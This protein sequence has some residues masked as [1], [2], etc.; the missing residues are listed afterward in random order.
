MTTTMG[1]PAFM[2]PEMCG[3]RSAPFSPFPAEVWAIG[4]CLH[5]FVYGKGEPPSAH[6]VTDTVLLQSQRANHFGAGIVW[7]PLRSAR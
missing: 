2:A 4:V 5:M 1:T 7:L 6:T 3:S